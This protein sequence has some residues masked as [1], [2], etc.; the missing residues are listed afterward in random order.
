MVASVDVYLSV[1]VKRI[2]DKTYEIGYFNN[3]LVSP[4]Y[5]TVKYA[6]QYSEDNKYKA[7]GDSYLELSNKAV[8]ECANLI[9]WAKWTD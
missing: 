4:V 9:N 7:F 2:A 6:I 8:Y 3:F 5:E 1:S